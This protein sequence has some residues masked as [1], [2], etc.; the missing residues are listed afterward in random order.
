MKSCFFRAAYQQRDRG[1]EEHCFHIFLRGQFNIWS[2]TIV[3]FYF[4]C[5]LDLEQF[6][7]LF[8]LFLFLFLLLLL[9]LELPLFVSLLLAVSEF[10]LSWLLLR[11]FLD[12]SF[13]AF[14]RAFFSASFFVFYFFNEALLLFAP[15]PSFTDLVFVSFSNWVTFLV[16]LV[17]ISRAAFQLP[18][19]LPFQLRHLLQYTEG[20][21]SPFPSDLI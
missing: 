20:W 10:L 6:P 9:E 16:R 11:W 8:P 5:C 14:A 17:I 21:L 15:R 18:F 12:F 7:W 4:F 1:I 19:P 3:W 2:K 13:L